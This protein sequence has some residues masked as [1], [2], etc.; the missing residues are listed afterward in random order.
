MTWYEKIIA[1]H[2]S[3][4]PAVSHGGRL[5]SDRYFV[6]QEESAADLQANNHHAEKSMTG[7]TDL[8]T[9]LEFDPWRDAFEKSLDK[10]GIA[11]RLHSVQYEEDTKFWHWRWYWG[12]R[13]G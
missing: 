7:Y 4:T 9:K 10:R 2:V 8:F 5:R 1:A 6:W 13:Y 12:V 11:W 3:V